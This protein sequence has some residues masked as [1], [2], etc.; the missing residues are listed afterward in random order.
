MTWAFDVD[1]TLVGSI[2]SDVLRPGATELLEALS[3][4]GVDRVL[5]SAG[6]ADYA[7]RM[8]AAHGIDDM[9]HAFH[10]KAERGADQ[11]YLIDHLQ[12]RDDALIFVD[13]S[14]VDLPRGAEIIRVSQFMGNNPADRA[15]VDLLNRL[16]EILD[17]D[18]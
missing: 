14:P 8:A 6:G 9:F 7:R 10:A 18:D 15:L 5:W 16:D 11:R 2:R 17:L 1:G 13:D 4:R 3:A 12:T